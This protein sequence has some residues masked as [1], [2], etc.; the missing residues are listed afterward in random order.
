VHHAHAQTPVV[1]NNV[2]IRLSTASDTLVATDLITL[3]TKEHFLIGK[4]IANDN[5]T[6]D[7]IVVKADAKLHPLWA[8]RL[9]SSVNDVK[10]TFNKALQCQNGDLLVAGYTTDQQ[11]NDQRLIVLR[12][13]EDG[14]IVWQKSY[15]VKTTAPIAVTSMVECNDNS[16]VLLCSNYFRANYSPSEPLHSLISLSKD[17]NVLNYVSFNSTL[18]ENSQFFLT[19]VTYQNHQLLIWG[20]SY[21][22]ECNSNDSRSIFVLELNPATF[23][24]KV[25]IHLCFASLQPII[26]STYTG[27][28]ILC[29][30][31]GYKFI[32]RLNES[33][34]ARD[35]AQFNFSP[36]VQFEN[37]FT[38]PEIPGLSTWSQ[39]TSAPDGQTVLLKWRGAINQTSYVSLWKPN[40]QLEDGRKIIGFGTNYKTNILEPGSTITAGDGKITFLQSS[41]YNG[42]SGIQL[43]TV[44]LNMQTDNECSAKDTTFGATTPM[45]LYRSTM[46]PPSGTQDAVVFQ[47]ANLIISDLDLIREEICEEISSCDVLNISGINNVCTVGA[48]IRYV[49]R[50]NA[51]CT[52]IIKWQYDS[53]SVR[54]AHEVNDSTIEIIWK[55]S[56]YGRDTTSLTA[57]LSAGKINSQL[58]IYLSSV[59]RPLAQNIKLC[60][61]DSVKLTVGNWLSS[62]RWQ[63]NSTDSV[64][65]AKTPGKYWVDVIATCGA[66]S[67]DTTVIMSASALKPKSEQHEICSGDSLILYATQGLQNY[68]WT[69]T[70]SQTNQPGD[71][72]TIHP[73]KTTTYV[74]VAS[75]VEGCKNLDSFLVIVHPLPQVRLASK[76][77]TCNETMITI[78]K[79]TGSTHY[80]W[81]TGDT[82]TSISIS[83]SGVYKVEGVSPFGCQSTAG[84]EIK[85]S[86]CSQVVRFP[87][88]FSPN[89]DG[90][91]DVFGRMQN[92]GIKDFELRIYNKWGGLVF[93]STD[94]EQG[95]DGRIAGRAQ[96]TGV[97]A[98]TCT[99]GSNTNQ[100]T[101][102]KGTVLLVH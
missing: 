64:F 70:D 29:Y 22:N 2:K 59:Y 32:M 101:T 72:L 20:I 73:R 53:A 27:G 57:S 42:H 91:N 3:A 84:I 50:R 34:R 45:N 61:G 51:G 55:S 19:G 5:S 69:A 6:T 100:K 67:S 31:G 65:I 23:E 10:F 7:G 80:H 1:S 56:H 98:W 28:S 92:P 21:N 25:L 40:G 14:S 9:H 78:L 37:A 41:T 17:G 77:I 18:Q 26:S 102:L 62:Y 38:W 75:S 11:T 48:P 58:P 68:A 76:D 52:N 49:A 89:S 30:P 16:I 66:H 35:I 85:V 86:P 83:K 63:D 39:F 36:T 82:T 74:A 54:R 93:H 81:N 12:V 4:A 46:R 24:L 8:K 99:Y 71:A 13:S 60:T 43:Q 33:G 95:W 94:P 79:D 96:D 90:L 47:D 88:A 15:W 44:D 87:N 97:Y